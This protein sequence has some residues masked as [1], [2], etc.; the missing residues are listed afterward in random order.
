MKTDLLP[1]I[2]KCLCLAW[3]LA[4]DVV[5]GSEHA[6]LKWACFET[7]GTQLPRYWRL[8]GSDQPKI[9]REIQVFEDLVSGGSTL[10][11]QSPSSKYACHVDY[12]KEGA[13]TV[14]WYA[15]HDRSYCRTKAEWLVKKLETDNLKCLAIDHSDKF[16]RDITDAQTAPLPEHPPEEQ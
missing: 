9:E 6:V 10:K 5:V 12:T 8:I 13:T 4:S 15:K 14:L 7:D 2:T 3:M 1:R 11:G 16:H